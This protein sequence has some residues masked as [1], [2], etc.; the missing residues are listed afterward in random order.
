MDLLIYVTLRGVLG[1]FLSSVL[2]VAGF[3]VTFGVW[4]PTLG[5]PLLFVLLVCGA[6]LGAGT[7][8]SIAWLRPEEGCRQAA[9]DF[10]TG[11]VGA[12]VGAVGGLLYGKLAYTGV[13]Y[14][15][16]GKVSTI[17]GAAFASNLTFTIVTIYRSR[18]GR[19]RVGR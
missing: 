11:L 1:A 12:L 7:G 19:I 9:L 3:F 16:S 8:G 4:F 13:L 6:G 2:G 17:L 18:C 10:A 14:S 5:L 15:D